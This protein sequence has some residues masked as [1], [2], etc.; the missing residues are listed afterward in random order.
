MSIRSP[1][2]SYQSV[3]GAIFAHIF[4]EF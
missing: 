4:R 1:L 2:F 3:L